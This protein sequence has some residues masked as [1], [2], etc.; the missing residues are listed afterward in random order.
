MIRI[1][2]DLVLKGSAQWFVIVVTLFAALGLGFFAVL[3]LVDPGAL[4]PGGD[5]EAA[6][7]FASYLGPRNLA[8]G[9]AAVLL[10]ALRHWRALGLVLVLMALVQAGDA[11]LG[12]IRQE[13]LQT[14]S[15]AVIAMALLS[16][17]AM[18]RRGDAAVAPEVAAARS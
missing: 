14:I 13:A 4:V 9:G 3:G 5:T 2:N 15:P 7:Q 16:A 12:A 6:R 8:L 17:A 1:Q 11:I 18:I 10:L